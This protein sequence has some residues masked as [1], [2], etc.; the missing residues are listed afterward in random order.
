[1]ANES[2]SPDQSAD[3]NK[4]KTP[5]SP[6][7]TNVDFMSEALER[8]LGSNSDPSNHQL[9]GDLGG[10]GTSRQSQAIE[11]IADFERLWK[12]QNGG[13]DD[14]LGGN[15]EGGGQDGSKEEGQDG[16]K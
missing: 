1:M 2:S 11:A 13:Q 6:P 15:K 4:G 9:V 8:Y 5:D 16:S 7:P 12:S 14:S 10:G 3:V